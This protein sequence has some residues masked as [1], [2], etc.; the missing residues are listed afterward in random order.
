[1]TSESLQWSP[2]PSAT[3]AEPAPSIEQQRRPQ[4]LRR[5][6]H[7]AHAPRAPRNQRAH[8]CPARAQ[9]APR[10]LRADR[11]AAGQERRPGERRR[12]AGAV[13][14]APGSWPRRTAPASA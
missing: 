10:R 2:P 12:H 7:H 13:G 9:R 4:S 1:L 8:R 3:S 14:R 11:R 5:R 6:A